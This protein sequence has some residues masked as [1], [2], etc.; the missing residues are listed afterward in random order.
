[1]ITWTPKAA[2][3]SALGLV[4]ATAA[5]A[6][7]PNATNSSLGGTHLTLT[8]YQLSGGVATPQPLSGGFE[9]Q[10]ITV[11]D[12]ANNPVANSVVVL[13]FTGCTGGV[14]PKLSTNQPLGMTLNA[15]AKTISAA[16]NASGVVV[17]KICGASN[18]TVPNG[19]EPLNCVS[20]SADGVPLGTFSCATFDENGDGDINGS[21]TG[22]FA[23]DRFGI[24]RNRSDYNKDNVVTGPDTSLF[25]NARFGP[26]GG[27]PLG[28]VQVGQLAPFVF[29]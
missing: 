27:H 19:S 18:N 20:V 11:R 22:L 12:A 17:F 24:Y 5:M 28:G 15:G 29:P 9:A 25:A 2:L 23:N 21:D 6:G 8:G 1:M 3:L 13:N 26:Y 14:G 10:S 7:V 16:T 4:V